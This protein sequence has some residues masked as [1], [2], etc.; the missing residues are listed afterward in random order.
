MR[1]L[2]VQPDQKNTVGFQNLGTSEPLGL[3]MIAGALTPDHEVALLDL[4]MAPDML[5]TTLA[6]FK[7]EA[8]GISSTFTVDIYQSLQVARIAKLANPGTFVFVGGHHASLYPSDFDEP[9]VDA[10]VVGEGEQ[11]AHE[12]VNILADGGS[13]R[14]VCGLIVNTPDGQVKTGVRPLIEHLDD[15]PFPRRDLTRKQGWVYKVVMTGPVASVET[16]RG[17]PYQCNFCSVWRF[18]QAKVRFKSPERVVDELEAID[19]GTVTFTDDNFLASI[20][21]AI[22]IGQLIEER[23]IQ[24][25]YVI[26][27][28]SDFDCSSP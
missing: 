25:K 12:M 19:E 17:C 21:R 22:K 3:E 9:V 27:A 28:R 1:V 4:R 10:I 6:D 20:P 2:L 26:Q 24:K 5:E 16:T 18:Y 23:G 15:L 13:L 14:Q 8:I 7:P 11:T